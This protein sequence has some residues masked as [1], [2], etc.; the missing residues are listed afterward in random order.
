MPAATANSAIML[1]QNHF[2]K[3]NWLYFGLFFIQFYCAGLYIED[4]GDALS[5]LDNLLAS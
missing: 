3:P 5:G 1:S 2:P 4:A